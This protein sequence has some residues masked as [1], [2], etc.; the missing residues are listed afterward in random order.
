MYSIGEKVLYGVHGVCIIE[1]IQEQNFTGQKTPYYT[2][3]SYQNESLQLY[4][5][6]ECENSKLEP[7]IS[8]ETATEIL[9]V[10]KK[11]ASEWQDRPTSR[12]NSYRVAFN[13]SDHF[14]I[15]QMVN[16]MLRK[17]HEL[18]REDKKLP[19]QDAQNLLKVSPILYAELALSLDMTSEQ[20]AKKIEELILQNP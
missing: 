10:F 7:V 13:S 1:D 15:A 18:A 4:H 17:K 5:P 2:L 9:D 19:S 16:T 6:V 12:N 3:R 8:A 20:I 11:P 14:E